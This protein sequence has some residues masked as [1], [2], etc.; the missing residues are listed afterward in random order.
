MNSNVTNVLPYQYISFSQD[1]INDEFIKLFNSEYLSLFSKINENFLFIDTLENIGFKPYFGYEFSKNQSKFYEKKLVS[2]G[3]YKT[4]N[5]ADKISI[6]ITLFNSQSQEYRYSHLSDIFLYNQ[7]R[8]RVIT[9]ENFLLYVGVLDESNSIY[10]INTAKESYL[11]HEG[12]PLVKQNKSVKISYLISEYLDDEFF[13]KI[14]HSM[15]FLKIVDRYT[16]KFI[17]Y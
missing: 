1:S 13:T 11:I 16:S 6:T 14:P 10:N 2:C 4:F 3:F 7:L 15:E 12:Y 5:Y 8:E 17:V 9:S